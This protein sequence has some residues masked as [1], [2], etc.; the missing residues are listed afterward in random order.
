M[1]A[2]QHLLS[3]GFSFERDGDRL[4][5][6]PASLLTDQLRELIR[7]HRAELLL[8]VQSA[9]DVYAE[10]VASINACCAARGDDERNRA[11]L[12]AEAG[13]LSP[14]QQADMREHFQVEAERFR[15]ATRPTR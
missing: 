7:G 15:A 5:V 14:E 8:S 4:I 2:V 13:L 3:L 1:G 10:L 11:D 9:S 12:I 6:S